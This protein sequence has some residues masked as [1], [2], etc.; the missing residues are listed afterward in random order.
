MRKRKGWLYLAGFVTFFLAML[1]AALYLQPAA[2]LPDLT[3]VQAGMPAVELQQLVGLPPVNQWTPGPEWG[4]GPRPSRACQWTLS[5][6]AGADYY[7]RFVVGF[8]EGDRV[9]FTSRDRVPIRSDSL[10]DRWRHRLFGP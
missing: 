6:G 4:V 7:L 9:M 8:D 5:P 2:V 1:A 3:R 10:F